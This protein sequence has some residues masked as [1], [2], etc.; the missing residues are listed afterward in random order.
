MAAT[1]VNL[2]TGKCFRVVS[3][4]ESRS[5]AGMY[6]PDVEGK[7]DQQLEAYRRM[8]DSVL[9]RVQKVRVKIDECD[10]P[11]PTRR[12]VACSRCG[13]IVRDG[14][15][16]AV[17]G[18][19]RCKPCTEGC[20]FVNAL[21]VSWPEMNWIPKIDTKKEDRRNKSLLWHH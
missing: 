5:L 17:D 2:E 8:P 12:K 4:E 15:E 19:V 6:A 10:L 13:Q 21:E 14:R 3:T 20:Y 18:Q 11:G 7:A 16:V 9:F 1:F